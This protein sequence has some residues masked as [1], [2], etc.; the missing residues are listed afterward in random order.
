MRTD[1]GRSVLARFVYNKS[2][3]ALAARKAGLEVAHP[4]LDAGCEQGLK[5]LSLEIRASTLNDVPVSHGLTTKST[6]T[7]C[8]RNGNSGAVC[9]I[10]TRFTFTFRRFIGHI[11]WMKALRL[12]S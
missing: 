7:R 12:S 9:R 4:G 8:E 3:L 11:L 2:E 6:P 1:L 10:R 5:K